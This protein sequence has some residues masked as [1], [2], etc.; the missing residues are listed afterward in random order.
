[1]GEVYLAEDTKLGR[2]VAIKILP[3]AMAADTDRLRRFQ[4]E[5]RAVAALNHPNIITIH[6]VEEEE[7][8]HFIT[9]ERVAGDSLVELI[10][11]AGFGL[12]KLLELGVQ[13]AEALTT[14]HEAGIAHRDLKPA[15]VMVTAKGRLKVL[16]FGLAKLQPEGAEPDELTRLPTLTMTRKGVIV[17]TAPYMSPEQIEG[18]RV[19]QRTDLFSLGILLYEMTTGR[20]PFHGETAAAVA[21]SILRDTPPTVTE[22]RSNLPEQLGRIIRHCLH[23]DPERRFQ[24]A[25]DVRNELLDLQKEINASQAESTVSASDRSSKRSHGLRWVAV[26]G[27][28][29]SLLVALLLGL[30]FVKLSQVRTVGDA[31]PEIRSLAVLPFDNLMN[32]PEQDYFVE[33]MHE[34]LLT[35]LSKIR[36]V[37]VISRTSAMLYKDSD[38]PLPQIA[39]ELDVDALVEGSVLRAG[40][41]V[42]ITAQLIHGASDEH[43]WAESYD[44]RLENVLAVL[45]EVAQTVAAEIEVT[46]TP[47]EARRVSENEQVDPQALEAYLRGRAA[48]REFTG[49]GFRKSLDFYRDAIEIEPG[50]ALA[51]AGV[52]AA[53]L[54]LGGF[55]HEPLDES[56]EKARA[57]AERA[58]ELNDNLDEGYAALGWVKLYFDWNFEGALR[59]FERALEINPNHGHANHGYADYLTAMGRPNEGVAYVQRAR[60]SDPLST[61]TNISFVGHLL[62]ARRYDEAIDECRTL[63]SLDPDSRAIHGWLIQALWLNGQFEEWEAELRK[64][65]TK[66]PD[67]IA[68][69]DKGSELSGPMG[70]QRALAHEMEQRAATGPSNPLPLARLFGLVGEVDAT[71]AWLEKAYE[72]RVPQLILL[73]SDP[74]FDSVRTDPRY[75]DLLQ[76]LNLPSE[77]PEPDQT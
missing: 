77:P 36:A 3:A 63:L 42:R 44:R 21:S 60:Q 15:N 7:G 54:L 48:F 1:M 10:P 61:M 67:L 41:Q 30:K 46:L 57:A 6:S 19:D 64:R 22:V 53:H 56:A 13:L 17:G 43:L 51:H 49:A 50:Y 24:S 16:D 11:R 68:A 33:G 12:E 4:R 74:S 40:D 23:K 69:I 9:M 37:R 45:S 2:E 8:V 32:D 73:P 27:I 31:R 55:G 34:A 28:G 35:D 39:R 26:G 14:A 52:A 70:A 76:R 62:V 75:Q 20:R 66:N 18:D 72:E 58:L 29:V 5:A 59:E 38:K 25:K 71:L 47:Q 65:W